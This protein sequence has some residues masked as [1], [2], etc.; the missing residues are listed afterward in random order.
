LRITVAWDVHQT[1]LKITDFQVREYGGERS[2]ESPFRYTGFV[3]VVLRMDKTP[4]VRVGMNA[5][6]KRRNFL[7]GYPFCRY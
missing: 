2:H 3:I 7:T 4:A 5:S 6:D 1:A